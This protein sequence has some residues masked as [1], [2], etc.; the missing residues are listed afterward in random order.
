LLSLF[1]AWIASSQELAGHHPVRSFK[2]HIHYSSLVSGLSKQGRSWQA[3]PVF[4]SCP[5]SSQ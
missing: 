5:Y 1:R 3:G 4:P 2:G